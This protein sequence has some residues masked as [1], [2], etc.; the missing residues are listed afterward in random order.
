MR[1]DAVGVLSRLPETTKA[2]AK[3][4]TGFLKDVP[5]PADE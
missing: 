1:Q 4:S 3:M 2:D 5:F